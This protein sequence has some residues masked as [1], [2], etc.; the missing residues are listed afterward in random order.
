MSKVDKNVDPLN[1]MENQRNAKSTTREERLRTTNIK[2]KG[3]G[4]KRVKNQT[5]RTKTETKNN[6]TRN[7]KNTSNM[8]DSMESRTQG[9]KNMWSE[10]KDGQILPVSKMSVWKLRYKVL[11]C[12][13]VISPKLQGP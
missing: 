11:V 4:N 1:T 13:H 5:I 12:S 3:K 6:Q 8:K 9:K 7:K 2:K 10:V